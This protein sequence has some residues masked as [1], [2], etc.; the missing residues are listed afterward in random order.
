MEFFYFN[1]VN[2]SNFD[3]TFHV[4]K[5]NPFGKIF[6]SLV[7]ITGR[8]SAGFKHLAKHYLKYS[9]SSIF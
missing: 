8:L 6:A 9:L 4:F 2:M 3:W 7:I 5:I 1:F